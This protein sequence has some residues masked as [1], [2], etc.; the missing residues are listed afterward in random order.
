MEGGKIRTFSIVGA[1]NVASHIGTALKSA[2]YE[3]LGIIARGSSNSMPLATELQS[4][5]VDDFEVFKGLG[6]DLIIFAVPDDSITSLSERLAGVEGLIVHTSGT[7]SMSIFKENFSHYGVFYPLQSFSK[8]TYVAFSEVPICLEASSDATMSCLK[9]VAHNVSDVVREVPGEKRAYLHL[10]A[11][12]VNN[13]TNHL[14]A[15]A[16]KLCKQQGNDF[17]LFEP[18]A[19]ETIKKAFQ[20]NP[21]DAQTGPARRGD[22][23][24]LESHYEMLAD[25]PEL[26]E[27]YNN[28]ATSILRK[29]HGNFG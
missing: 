13:F 29:Y 17:A 7:K 18:L 12:F 14:L 20:Y 22:S 6:A 1:G 16:E 21:H 3:C 15:E 28:L 4:K 19:R 11:V 24:V 5:L 26:Q 2:G 8:D 25:D 10:A 9:E 23:S 27:L